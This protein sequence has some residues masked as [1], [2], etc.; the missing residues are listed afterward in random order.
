MGT[1]LALLGLA[2]LTGCASS[3][4]VDSDVS[5]FA[6]ANGAQRPASYRFERLPSQEAQGNS[7]SR[8]E[9]IAEVALQ[10]VGLTPSATVPKYSVQITVRVAAYL[11]HPQRVNSRNWLLDEGKDGTRGP[12]MLLNL[13]PTWYKHSVHLVLRDLGTG[14]VAYETQATHDGPWSDTLGLL[15]AI[16]D[17]ALA[18][19]PNPPQGPRN[20]VVELHNA[21]VTP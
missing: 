20:I 14:Q 11:R 4:M 7:Q 1:L 21:S 3:R 19:Y 13:E 12:T 16:L 18:D 5:A 2:V 15:P 17:A 6:G 9:S 8:I 10:N